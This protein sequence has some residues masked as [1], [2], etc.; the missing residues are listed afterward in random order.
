MVWRN[1]TVTRVHAGSWKSKC[2]VWH[3]RPWKFLKL[4]R[5]GIIVEIE[6][7]LTNYLSIGLSW[8]LRH[9][10]YSASPVFD[11]GA[12]R[13]GLS[14]HVWDHCRWYIVHNNTLITFSDDGMC[15]NRLS[16]HANSG[17]M[18]RKYLF[19]IFVYNHDDKHIRNAT[20]WKG[21][22]KRR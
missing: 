5:A 15:A 21:T 8:K 20:I 12:S 3:N 19:W 18:S 4:V 9:H 14:L 17:D 13:P 10:L 2:S 6:M 22:Q 11:D 16:F 7:S 1:Q